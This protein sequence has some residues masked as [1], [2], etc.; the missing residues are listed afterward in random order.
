MLNAL[1]AAYNGPAAAKR[2]TELDPETNKLTDK[3]K[4]VYM[5]LCLAADK[6]N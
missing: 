5:Q 1:V 3:Q 6:H 4:L 2:S